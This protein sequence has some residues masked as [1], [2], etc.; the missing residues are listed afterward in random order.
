MPVV[1]GCVYFVAAQS[2]TASA[3]MASAS[4]ARVTPFSDLG[5]GTEDF[6]NAND[7]RGMRTVVLG[8]ANGNLASVNAGQAVTATSLRDRLL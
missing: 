4:D 7:D 3:T 5:R 1:N 8:M 2:A 6:V